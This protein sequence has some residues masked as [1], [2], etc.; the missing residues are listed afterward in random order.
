MRA[1]FGGFGART[2]AA[3]AMNAPTSESCRRGLKRRSNPI[4]VDGFE[5]IAFPHSEPATWPGNTSTPSESSIKRRERVE[6]P[7]GS[8]RGLDREI[9]SG[10]IADEQR[11][12]GEH[13]PRLVP[14]ELSTTVRQQCSGRWPGVWMTPSVTAPTVISSPSCIGSFG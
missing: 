5:L 9:G 7:F 2:V 6:Q 14:R 1:R 11:V 13:E 12:A 4:V 10:S 8:L 3:S